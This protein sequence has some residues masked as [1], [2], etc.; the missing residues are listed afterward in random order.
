MA[1]RLWLTTSSVAVWVQHERAVVA[2][3]VDGAL[4]GT[5]VVLVARGERGRMERPDG[6]VVV[7][8]GTRGGRAR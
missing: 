1:Q 3:V 5:A 6:R 7:R 8:P 2:R 4:A